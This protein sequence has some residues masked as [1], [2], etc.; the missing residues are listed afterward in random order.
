MSSSILKA[1]PRTKL[2]SRAARDL[3]AMGQ[4]PASIQGG[5]GDHLDISVDSQ[6]VWAMRRHHVHLFDLEVGGNT[7]SATIRE[8]QWDPIS[9]T[10]NHIEFRRVV[11]G[12]A[13]DVEVPLAFV[14]HPKGGVLNHLMDTLEVRCLPS[15][16]PDN[17]EVPVSELE[18]GKALTAGEI[19][20]PEGFELVTAADAAVVNIVEA[21]GDDAPAEEG[22]GEGEGDL[23]DA[24]TEG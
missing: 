7:E 8:L 24:P 21:G 11:R 13:V 3:R 19:E 23:G 10:I 20:L 17:I 4:I 2:G 14:G 6:E 12:V 9:E 1:E 5:E 16:I 22:D 15:K 18:A